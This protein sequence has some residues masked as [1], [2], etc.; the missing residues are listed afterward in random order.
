VVQTLSLPDLRPLTTTRLLLPP[1]TN[2]THGWLSPSG[3]VAVMIRD[4]NRADVMNVERDQLILS[5]AALPGALAVIDKLD[6]RMI[7]LD[8]EHNEL[9]DLQTGAVIAL[10]ERA[11]FCRGQWH[12]GSFSDDGSVVVAGANCGEVFAWNARTGKLLRH[13]VLP[14]QITGVALGHDSRTVAVAS[15]DGRV[16]LL[17]LRSFAQR[18][19]PGPPRGID[20]L[21][22]SAGDRLLGAGVVDGTVRIWDTAS[23]R[24]M[25]ELPL[26]TAVAVRFTPDGRK[27]VT[28]EL[29]GVMRVF[30]P[31]P[32]CGNAD[33]L[34]SEAARRVTRQLTPAEKKTYL[35]GF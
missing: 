15:P 6:R 10:P 2:F 18:S 8:G 26:Q 13:I 27:L 21:D 11:Q 4:D 23:G 22:F 7:L 29:N 9:I 14:G 16:T 35:S 25:R 20:S 17:D 31:C 12:G 24:L 5:E 32:G 33:A 30:D 28:T 1:D 34:L 19:I 3:N